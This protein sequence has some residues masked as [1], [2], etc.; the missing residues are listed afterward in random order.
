M[1]DAHKP[2]E[3]TVNEINKKFQR[4]IATWAIKPRFDKTIKKEMKSIIGEC[5]T[6][7]RIVRF[8]VRGTSKRYA[9][10][11]HNFVAKTKVRVLDSGAGVGGSIGVYPGV[12]FGGIEARDT[13]IVIKEQEEPLFQKRVE[14][15][16]KDF[17]R[18]S[19]HAAP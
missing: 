18:R 15:W 13:D 11:S 8:L 16:L 2:V 14:K 17:R 1:T 12:D 3:E 7:N 19:R 4:F 9:K 6:D 10:M 5:S